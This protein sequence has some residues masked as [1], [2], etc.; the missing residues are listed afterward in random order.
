MS[1]QKAPVII[2]EGAVQSILAFVEKNSIEDELDFLF[3]NQSDD[4]EFEIEEND[5]EENLIDVEEEVPE[6]EKELN[7]P[8]NQ[9]FLTRN[10]WNLRFPR[11]KSKLL[12]GVTYYNVKNQVNNSKVLFFLIFRV[13]NSMWKKL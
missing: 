1:K 2:Y 5:V 7:P 11:H 8:R 10:R 9:K 13:N 12:N 3:E 4:D 6:Q